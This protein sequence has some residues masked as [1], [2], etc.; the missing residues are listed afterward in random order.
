MRSPSVTS[1]KVIDIEGAN[2]GVMENVFFTKELMKNDDRIYVNPM[3]FPD[4]HGNYFTSEVRKYPVEFPFMQK[5]TVTARIDIPQ[6]YEVEEMPQN[7]QYTFNN[8]DMNVA[9]GFRVQGNTIMTTYKSELNTVKVM[10]NDYQ[11]LRDFW[12]HLLELNSLNVVLK[13]K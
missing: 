4:E 8:G 2:V 13:K 11:A 3:V 1:Y 10:P 9:I 12:N 5:T 7:A 6:N